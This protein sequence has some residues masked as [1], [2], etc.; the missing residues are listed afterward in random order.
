[1]KKIY[2]IF[3]FALIFLG[4]VGALY[5]PGNPTAGSGEGDVRITSQED[6]MMESGTKMALQR[7]EYTNE[8]GQ[9]MRIREEASQIR[10]QVGEHV[11]NCEECNLTQE[12]IGN[13]TRIHAQ[14]SNGNQAEI[15]VMPDVASEVAIERHRMNMCENCSIEL[16][17]VGR[18]NAT[19]MAYEVKTQAQAKAL[20]IFKTKV[21][22]SVEVDAETG[23]V[24]RTRKPWWAV[25]QDSE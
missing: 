5:E 7:G 22:A 24:I 18:N 8:M 14:M 16:K 20:G 3:A 10:L 13:R 11:A 21:D 4:L 2:F 15:K 12:M 9:T 25:L 19:R 6:Q 23:E 1:M 17:E